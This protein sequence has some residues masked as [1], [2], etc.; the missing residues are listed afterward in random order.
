[1]G[2]GSGKASAN[3]VH[4]PKQDALPASLAAAQRGRFQCTLAPIAEGRRDFARIFFADERKIYFMSRGMPSMRPIQATTGPSSAHIGD[5]SEM[6]VERATALFCESLTQQM[7]QASGTAPDPNLVEVLRQRAMAA[8]SVNVGIE[9]ALEMKLLPTFLQPAFVIILL[10]NPLQ[11]RAATYGFV[12]ATPD[13]IQG[14][15]PESKR[16]PF[17]VRLLSPELLTTDAPPKEG[18]QTQWEVQYSLVG[19]RVQ[20]IL[21]AM[22][23]DMPK[24]REATTSARWDPLL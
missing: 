17:C 5:L 22:E 1:M 4:A 13:Q 7:T 20:T 12:A 2:C 8:M 3:Q 10:D 14:D 19:S 11:A 24:V 16:T 9:F 6:V 23:F 15:R 18:A 21:Q